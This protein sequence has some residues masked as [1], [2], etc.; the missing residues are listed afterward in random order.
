MMDMN[1]RDM[2]SLHRCVYC[3]IADWRN[4][5]DAAEPSSLLL[6]VVIID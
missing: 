2:Y 3:I 1:A 4:M 5:H 6:E